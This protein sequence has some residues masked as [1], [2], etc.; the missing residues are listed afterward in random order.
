MDQ[1]KPLLIGNGRLAKHI[2]HY[3]HQKNI[4]YFHHQNAR[5]FDAHFDNCL[6]ESTCVWL[7][8]SDQAIAQVYS[9]IAD[10]SKGFIFSCFHSSAALS[11]PHAVTIHPLQTFGPEF[12]SLAVYE[13]TVFTLIQE[14]QIH[15]VQQRDALLSA[16]GNP[17]QIICETE[18]TL[19]H[20][21]CSMI[22]NFP[23]ILWSAVFS[24]M[25]KTS[26][27]DSSAFKPLLIQAVSNFISYGDTALTG[28]LVRGDEASVQKHLVALST[29]PL[30]LIYQN[31][32]ALYSHFLKGHPSHDDRTRI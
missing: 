17:V 29:G 21:Y 15:S 2:A 8:V 6:R 16:F 26:H 31:F 22:A 12:Y 32:V 3:L 24:E 9:N 28:P 19:Y 30:A 1:F 18:R 25:R 13:A 5:K 14:E 7:L 11:H 27:F 23:Q 4:P 10:R 20:A